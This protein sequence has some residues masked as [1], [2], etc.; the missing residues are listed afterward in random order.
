MDN[1]SLEK[2]IFR[3]SE[4]ILLVVAI[5]FGA[6][7][8]VLATHGILRMNSVEIGIAIFCLAM[9]PILLYFKR[10]VRNHYAIYHT[11]SDGN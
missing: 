6:M 9:V 5:I 7:G 3:G 1:R 10:D 11:V 4:K 8:L 2:M